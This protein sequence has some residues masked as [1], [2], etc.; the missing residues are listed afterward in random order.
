MATLTQVDQH[1]IDAVIQD[2]ELRTGFSYP[3]ASLLDLAQNEDISVYEADLSTIGPN[4]SGILE[5]DD[6]NTKKNPRIFISSGINE[7]R[8]LFTLAHELGHHFLHEGRKLRLDTLDYSKKDKD[9]KE[10]SEANYFAA[11]LLVPKDQLIYRVNK[12]DE[13]RQ[14]AEYFRVSVPVILNRFKWLKTN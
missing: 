2:I 1:H 10:E 3:E 6:D 12:G 5:Y 14:I 4:I 7:N 9:T 8:K 11:T 13:V